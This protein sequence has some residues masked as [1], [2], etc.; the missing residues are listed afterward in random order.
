[1]LCSPHFF[2]LRVRPNMALPDF[3]AWQMN[4]GPFQNKV[5]LD[6]EGVTSLTL[7]IAD[8]RQILLALPSLDEQEKFAALYRAQREE[9]RVLECL[10][11]NRERQ[12]KGLATEMM[13]RA[14]LIDGVSR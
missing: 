11:E 2:H 10:I 7:R 9:R 6:A 5:R 1:V 4:Q 14:H 13:Q 8:F 12:M 3:I